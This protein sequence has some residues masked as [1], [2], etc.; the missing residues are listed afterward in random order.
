[1]A[2]LKLGTTIGG[3]EAL[4]KGNLKTVIGTGAGQV[5]EGNHTHSQYVNQNAFSNIAVS[6]QSTVAAD[7]ATD[8]LTLAAGSNI[9]ITTDATN[10]KITIANTYSYTHPSSHPA[11][12]ITGL[13]TV[14][15]SGSYNDLSNKPSLG[16]AASKNT[17]TSSGQIPL[18]GSNGKLPDSVIPAVAITDTFVVASETEMLALTAQR[19]DVAVRSDVKKTF[20]LKADDASVLANWV[21]VLTPADGVQSVNGK[22]GASITLNASDVSARPNTWIPAWGDVTGKPSA[23]TT[24]AGIVQLN[25]AV[26][27]TSTTQA[28]T[29]NA[30]KKAYDLANGKLGANATAVAANKLATARTITL[31][32]DLTGSVSFDGSANVTLSAQVAD[33]SHSHTNYLEK[34]SGGSLTI[35]ADSEAST[36]TENLLLKAG[37]NE[38]KVTSS[39]GG[40]TVTKSN[41]ALTFNGNVVYHAGNKPTKSDVGLGNVTN[42]SKATMFTNPTFTGTPVAPTAAS[43]TNTTQVA[44]TAF[45]MTEVGKKANASH[46]NHV[47]ATETANNAKF[48]RNDNT[49]QLVTPANIGALPSGGTAVAANKLATARKI[50]GVAFDGTADITIKAQANGGNADTVDNL[51]ASSFLRSDT[52]NGSDLRFTSTDGRGVRFWDSDN[53][54]IYMAASTNA[55]LG[56][57]FGSDTTSDYNM[58]FKMSEGTNRGFVFKNGSTNVASIDATGNIKAKNG[59]SIGSDAFSLVYD[60]ENEC[61]NFVFAE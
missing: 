20:I 28:A 48:L 44:T 9:S 18:I 4:H 17:G 40:S 35:H 37:H 11:S 54:K 25:D 56:G 49:W 58:Y 12:M 42:E 10:D 33:N 8:T 24:V 13:S 55:T 43:G 15:T 51:H 52:G 7:S 38:L 47:P 59:I 2:Q 57:R 19:G 29:A 6:G 41:T 1:M 50:N 14:A 45:V 16:S 46:G 30:V 27:S 31:G 32:G 34:T 39:A 60:A 36:D 61:V 26:N 21:E 22:T 53:F 3:S 5:A 23:S